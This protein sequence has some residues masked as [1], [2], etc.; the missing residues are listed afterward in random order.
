MPSKMTTGFAHQNSLLAKK[1]LV[2]NQSSDR[3]ASWQ[4]VGGKVSFTVGAAQWISFSVPFK[5]AFL[6]RQ[7][8]VVDRFFLDDNR[9]YLKM[10]RFKLSIKSILFQRYRSF[11][12]KLL[13]FVS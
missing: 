4:A 8:S 7:V 1:F 11:P 13:H 12:E 3:P 10:F 6:E 2:M 9:Q 5:I